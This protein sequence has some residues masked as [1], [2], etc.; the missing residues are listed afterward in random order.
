MKFRT[1]LG[2]VIRETRHE[3][4]LG[5]REVAQQGRMAL[6]YLSEVERGR[7]EASS[8]ILECISLGLGIPLSKLIEQAAIRIRLDEPITI[9]DFKKPKLRE[10]DVRDEF[11]LP[12][13]SH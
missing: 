7:K 1:A 12:I 4:G 2:E 6:G 10:V 13:F 5:M 8:E 11:D 9:E 3:L